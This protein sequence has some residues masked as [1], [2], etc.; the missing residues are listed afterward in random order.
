MKKKAI[1]IKVLI[2]DLSESSKTLLA[3]IMSTVWKKDRKEQKQ[4]DV[5]TSKAIGK[6]VL[7]VVEEYIEDVAEKM[8]EQ[9][10]FNEK[11]K[12]DART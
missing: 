11:E 2:K 8:N 12:D 9:G 6:R 7:H 10:L 1:K 5:E 3:L 4:F